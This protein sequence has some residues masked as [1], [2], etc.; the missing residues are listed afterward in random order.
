LPFLGNTQAVIYQPA[1]GKYTATLTDSFGC[2]TT[3]N[4]YIVVSGVSSIVE[5]SINV[6]PN[7][8]TNELYIENV[9]ANISVVTLTDLA[10]KVVMQVPN[11]GEKRVKLSVQSLSSGIYILE[12]G[13]QRVKVMVE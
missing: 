9:E 6:Y 2:V 13:T 8:A 10:G 7:P 1:A 3:T 5:E 11:N 4:K 12:T